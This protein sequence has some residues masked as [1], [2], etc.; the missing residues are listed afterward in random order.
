MHKRSTHLLETELEYLSV[1]RVQ[2]SS[3]VVHQMKESTYSLQRQY[4]WGVLHVL[5]FDE[6]LCFFERRC[7]C[8]RRV[9]RRT[10]NTVGMPRLSRRCASSVNA[11]KHLK[12][13]FEDPPAT[14]GARGKR[15]DGNGIR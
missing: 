4:W 13:F 5:H 6:Q 14:E 9:L 12:T 8:V 3:R 1:V 2:K 7:Q 15:D 10:G 11:L